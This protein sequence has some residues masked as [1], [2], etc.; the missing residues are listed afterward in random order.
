MPNIV[1]SSSVTYGE[2]AFSTL[3]DVRI[4]EGR[5][6]DRTDLTDADLLVIRSTTPVR[7]DMLTDSRLRFVGTAT[8]GVDHMDLAHFDRNGI[9]WEHAPGCNAVS[10]AEY[11]TSV[12]LCLAAEHGVALEGRTLGVVG[13]GHVGSRVARKAAALGMRVLLND[14]PK[15]EAGL[16][17][18]EASGLPNAAY[19]DLETLLSESDLVTMHVPLTTAGPHT[20]RHMVDDG[21]CA[22][23]K[24]GCVFIN[25]ARG[26]IAQSDALIKAID[27]GRIAHAVI[28]TWEGEPCCP[29]DLLERV[30]LASPHIAGYGFDGKVRGTEMIYAAAC[31]FLGVAPTWT[32]AAQRP[33]PLVPKI[34]IAQPAATRDAFLWDVVRQTYDVR[35]D[36]ARMRAGAVGDDHQR[37]TDFDAQRSGYP[38]RREFGFTS[39][40]CKGA[41]PAWMHTL[42]ALGFAT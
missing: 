21:F 38:V 22:Q 26:P 13:V 39:V 2:A 12:W 10:V 6:I 14:P 16:S 20:T 25:A 29:Q 33:T 40:S 32:S 15:A 9:H 5:A 11:M 42:E 34:A 28:D 3:G 24:P 17:A 1:C 4:R 19:C 31:R 27:S 36:D 35:E 37:A 7:A 41:N 23:L 8:I 30:R 18:T